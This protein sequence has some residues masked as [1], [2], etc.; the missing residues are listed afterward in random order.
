MHKTARSVCPELSVWERMEI[1][2]G[3][4]SA[5]GRYVARVEDL[6]DNG[7]VVSSPDLIGG[8][9]L[10]RDNC[11]VAV[12]ITRRDAVYQF[13]SRIRRVSTGADVRY[14]LEP[15][16]LTQ[17]LQRRRFVRVA[18]L[19]HISIAAV[20]RTGSNV[21]SLAEPAWHRAAVVNLSGGGVLLRIEREIPVGDRVLLRVGSLSDIGLPTI[22]AGVCRRAFRDR[23]EYHAGVEFLRRDQLTEHFTD[24][25]LAVLPQTLHDFDQS[26]QNSLVTYV[27]RCQVHLRKRGLL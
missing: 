8:R 16:R 19:D 21:S 14:L 9:T 15:P 18:H 20:P 24:R 3:E 25:E 2:V 12:F 13:Y 17:R 6:T 27:F 1:V 7:I 11:Q 23:R 4:G 26:A 22:I 5:A 10:L